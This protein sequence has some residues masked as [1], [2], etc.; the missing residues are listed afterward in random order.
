MLQLIAEAAA[1]ARILVNFVSEKEA[2][3]LAHRGAVLVVHDVR[4]RGVE[5]LIGCTP[6]P[7][8]VA[9]GSHHFVFKP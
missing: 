6:Q 4:L 9:S 2:E 3:R 1:E 8:G 7:F 5:K